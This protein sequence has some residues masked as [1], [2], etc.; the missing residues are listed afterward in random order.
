ALTALLFSAAAVT[1]AAAEPTPAASCSA[2]SELADKN[3]ATPY[4]YAVNL[5]TGEVL[6]DVRGDALTPTAS[7]MK[8]VT[9]A[10]AYDYL[11]ANYAARTQVLADTNQVGTLYLK[12][13]GDHTLSR[14]TG[15]SYTT[16]SRSAPRLENLVTQTLAAWP[17]DVPITKIVVDASFFDGGGWNR[18]WPEYYR[19]SG[20]MSMITAL[21]VDADRK[22]PDLTDKKYDPFRST[23]PVQRV[24]KLF[25]TGLGDVA[26]DAKIVYS[27]TSDTATEIAGVNSRT[28]VNWFRH[29]L[30]V[31]DNTETEIIAFHA[32]KAAGRSTTWRNTT[33]L[34][35]NYMRS[36]GYDPKKLIFND[37]SGLASSNRLTA[38]A[39]VSVIQ[40]IHADPA[41]F[42]TFKTL[43]PVSGVSGSLASRM[44][45]T[46]RG[47][48]TAKVG[49]IP[50]LVS[51]AGWVDAEDGSHIAF[52]IFARTQGNT[53]ITSRTK[54]AIDKLVGRFY[55]C[56][57]ALTF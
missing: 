25:K 53:K 16:Y 45:G 19:R 40:A 8:L 56:G 17:K 22:N 3:L 54:P 30:M 50:G 15:S 37:N 18:N 29:A 28:I 4:V 39:V 34:A 41:K 1:P 13:G 38:K 26:K 36:I 48:V 7:V 43:L 46:L 12:G 42:E 49:F 5:D 47:K 6:L 9:I 2:K 32:A 14:L 24:A 10:W 52:A 20:D 35:R 57:A 31:S 27:K 51:L 55:A 11:N 44:T 21:M 33:K 23:Q